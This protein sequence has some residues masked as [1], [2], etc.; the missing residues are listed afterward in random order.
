METPGGFN[1]FKG[2][3]D[4]FGGGQSSGMSTHQQQVLDSIMA[5]PDEQG[6]SVHELKSKLR[7]MND[8]QVR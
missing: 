7:G 8:T 6:I 3:S 1:S 5:Y 2:G 4:A